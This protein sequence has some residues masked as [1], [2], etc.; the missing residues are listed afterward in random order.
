LVVGA[1]ATAGIY[2]TAKANS[3]KIKAKYEA[4]TGRSGTNDAQSVT[5]EVNALKVKA[6]D[7]S[8]AFKVV[9]I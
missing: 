8:E 6:N 1:A 2:A 5:N 3:N 9:F 4:T 7:I